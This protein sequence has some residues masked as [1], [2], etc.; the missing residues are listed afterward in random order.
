M[1]LVDAFLTFPPLLLAVA[2]VGLLGS[3]IQNV[4]LAM[5]LVQAPVLAR[6]VRGSALSAA[7]RSMFMAAGRLGRVLWR[8]ALSNV[9]R[10]IPLTDH[11]STDDHFCGGYRNRSGA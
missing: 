4:V 7:R 10:N 5:G 9:L 1:R 2:I 6:I 11:R 8:I 3:D